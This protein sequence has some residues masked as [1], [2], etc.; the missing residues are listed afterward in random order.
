ME[1]ILDD[2][3]G[4]DKRASNVIDRLRSLVRPGNARTASVSLNDVITEVLQFARHDLSD[5][6]V[7]IRFDLSDKLPDIGGDRIQL[8]QLLLN[9]ILNASDSMSGKP[10]EERHIQIS[11]TYSSDFV[12]GRGDRRRKWISR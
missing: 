3:V 6:G 7:T 10:V 4:E 11:S 8:Q 9:L 1:E 5:R 12:L 2:I